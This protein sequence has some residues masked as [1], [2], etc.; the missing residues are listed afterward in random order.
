MTL[1][2]TLPYAVLACICIAF[3]ACAWSMRFVQDDAYITLTYA[4]N[5][6]DGHGLVFN[7]GEHVE[8]FTSLTWTL[9]SALLISIGIRDVATALQIVGIA[10]TMLTLVPL[11]RIAQ[12]MLRHAGTAET[13]VPWLALL[14]PL[15][16]ASTA[17]VQYWSA[18]AMEA[19]FF[20]LL[21]ALTLEAFLVAPQSYR[22]VALGMLL[23]LT[24]PEAMLVVG[25]L[26][27]ARLLVTLR[28]KD[29]VDEQPLSRT[30][31]TRQLLLQGALLGGT[32]LALTAWRWFSYD[33]LLPNTFAAKTGFVY[34]QIGSG[35]EYLASHITN[36]WLWGVA[37]VPI[38]AAAWYV[39]NREVLLVVLLAALWTCAVVV[40]GGDVLRHQ[41]FL[42]PVQLILSVLLPVGSYLVLRQRMLFVALFTIVTCAFAFTTERDAIATT[43]KFEQELVSKMKRTGEWLKRS[44]ALN[45]RTYTIAATT[46]GALK[47][48][49]KQTVV[50]ML[51]LTDRTIATQPL[52]IPEVS[53]DSSVTWKE[54][55]YNADYVLSRKPDFI[56]FSTGI[57]PSAFA[58]RALWARQM[59]VDYYVFYYNLSGTNNLQSMFR[60]KPDAVLKRSP[61]Q[62]TSLTALQIQ[63]LLTYPKALTLVDASATQGKAEEMFRTMAADGPTNIAQPYQFIADIA[64]ARKNI[65]TAIANYSRAIA[66]D[67]CDIRSH[68][69]LLQISLSSKD[70]IAT[71]LHGDWVRRCNPVLLS[72]I[73]ISVREDALYR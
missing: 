2:R 53:N 13:V 30:T 34:D 27:A 54:R 5:L 62:R 67:P 16:F 69:A 66:I 57:K 59:Y 20:W 41:R 4:R 45:E 8:G 48:F 72:Q 24:R 50:D 11:F 23:L 17:A 21:V 36:V 32:L 68:F 6:V 43:S 58:E 73:G 71:E 64:M 31:L 38:V 63:A 51:G 28:N 60:R 9:L 14:A 39:R 10:C 22:W 33:A 12:R 15:F 1:I 56:V 49:S 42:I 52:S 47:Y 55:K 46:I 40:L 65:D 25:I 19:P 7:I 61:Q 44:A 26:F 3:A 29:S 37:F 70:T 35:L 18:S